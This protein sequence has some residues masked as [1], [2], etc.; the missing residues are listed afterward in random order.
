MEASSD[1]CWLTRNISFLSRSFSIDK[2]CPG[3]YGETQTYL[4]H[5]NEQAAAMASSPGRSWCRN[6]VVP[7]WGYDFLLRMVLLLWAGEPANPQRTFI[8]PP[9]IPA[10]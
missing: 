3:R 5:T 2:T 7:R 10:P 8:L 4:S 6:A 9:I 1:G